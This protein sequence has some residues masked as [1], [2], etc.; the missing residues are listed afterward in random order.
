MNKAEPGL[1]CCQLHS[2][3]TAFV[4]WFYLDLKLQPCSHSFVILPRHSSSSP[5]NN[6]TQLCWKI[7]CSS[8]RTILDMYKAVL[9]IYD[10]RFSQTQSKSI[11][12]VT[13]R[14]RRSSIILKGQIFDGIVSL[15]C[16]QEANRDQSSTFPARL[17]SKNLKRPNRYANSIKWQYMYKLKLCA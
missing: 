10:V 2:I 16:R 6:A 8:F 12:R 5:N 3:G 17:T 1:Q 11:P 15:L 7:T 14:V 13:S 4:Q 9:S